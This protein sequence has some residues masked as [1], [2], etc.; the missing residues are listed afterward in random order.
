[1]NLATPA[2]ARP[3]E[4][5]RVSMNPDDIYQN[6]MSIAWSF[7]YFM[8]GDKVEDLYRRA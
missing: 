1:M 2:T 4:D 6:P 3:K 7:D 8:S 5:W